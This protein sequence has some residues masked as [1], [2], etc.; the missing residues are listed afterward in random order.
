MNFHPPLHGHARVKQHVTSVLSCCICSSV[1]FEKNEFEVP[2][3]LQKKNRTKQ[4]ILTDVIDV[5]KQILLK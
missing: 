1:I 5:T 4:A 2:Y 3:V